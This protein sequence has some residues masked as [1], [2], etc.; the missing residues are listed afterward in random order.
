[1]IVKIADEHLVHEI[2]DMNGDGPVAEKRNGFGLR[3]CRHDKTFH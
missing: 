1:M 2:S 3:S